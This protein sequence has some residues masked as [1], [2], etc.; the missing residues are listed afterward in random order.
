VPALLDPKRST[1][2]IPN[3][4]LSAWA[5]LYLAL[6]WKLRNNDFYVATHLLEMLLIDPTYARLDFAPDL[7]EQLFR[8]HLANIEIWFQQEYENIL[9]VACMPKVPNLLKRG[10]HNNNHHHQK[11]D[12]NGAE[13]IRDEVGFTLII[14]NG[15]TICEVF[16]FL[17]V[18]MMMTTTMMIHEQLE[19]PPMP[20]QVPATG[21][22]HQEQ[23]VRLELLN[24]L[25]MDCLDMNT[26]QY[27][28]YYKDWM[29]YA[30]GG[31]RSGDEPSLPKTQTPPTPKQHETPPPP[32]VA[33]AGV[34]TM[35]LATLIEEEGSD[36]EVSG[37]R[38]I[39]SL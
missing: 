7:W 23:V 8:P 27:A 12:S 37:K 2:G 38:R 18:T 3:T 17:C 26:Q 32:K 1:A 39:N 13:S 36:D 28:Q 20:M 30:A 11:N 5:H 16:L 22:L 14:F 24:K 29:A 31:M 34:Q 33:A 19:Q 21:D 25:Y 10:V 35:P 4:Y 6:V 9:K 15:R